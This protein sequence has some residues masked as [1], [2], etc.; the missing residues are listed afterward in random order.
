MTVVKANMAMKIRR[1]P[2]AGPLP[3]EGR[4]KIPSPAR[5]MEYW[6]R[7]KQ[8]NPADFR[9]LGGESE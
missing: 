5:R 7:T 3:P 4:R 6:K 8:P 1:Y 9:L 2:D